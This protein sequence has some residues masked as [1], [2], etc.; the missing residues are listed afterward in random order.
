MPGANTHS[1]FTHFCFDFFS[2]LCSAISLSL[3]RNLIDSCKTAKCGTH[4]KCVIRDGQPKCVCAPKCKTKNQRPKRVNRHANA[5]LQ[6]NAQGLNG[7]SVDAPDRTLQLNNQSGNRHHQSIHID[8]AATS[9]D[10]QIFTTHNDHLNNR[11]NT[12]SDKIISIIAPILPSNLSSSHRPKKIKSHKTTTTTTT[13][14]PAANG[15][16]MLV[17]STQ[18]TQHLMTAS[19]KSYARHRQNGKN[20]KHKLST[21]NQYSNSSLFDNNIVN[22]NHRR[23]TSVEQ[24]FKSKFY[25]HDIPYPPIDLPNVSFAWDTKRSAEKNV[26]CFKSCS[27][28]RLNRCRT[29]HSFYRSF[30]HNMS[31]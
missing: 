27:N 31:S 28:T 14:T 5:Q 4:K 18:S 11:S 26:I 1:H 21:Q 20:H 17:K 29:F 23:Q 22:V 19:N 8:A 10:V 6:S 13:T 3:S 25:G 2:F 24:Q 16:R 30:R 15:R 7:R 12:K 9:H